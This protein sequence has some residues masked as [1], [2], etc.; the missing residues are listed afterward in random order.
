MARQLEDVS[1]ATVST[2]SFNA[3]L[4][5]ELGEI[6]APTTT[7]S[8]C[9]PFFFHATQNAVGLTEGVQRLL[10]PHRLG[11][12]VNTHP[13]KVLEA[14][15]LLDDFYL[16]LIDWAPQG[17]PIA[18]A[19]GKSIVFIER[20]LG[21]RSRS[22]RFATASDGITCIKHAPASAALATGLA[23]GGFLLW[24]RMQGVPFF[25]LP[26]IHTGRI[27]AISWRNANL[28]SVGGRDRKIQHI[29]TRAAS[30][31]F[32]AASSKP[33]HSQEICGLAWD[34][35]GMLLAS[36]GND[37][38]LLV[39][40]ARQMSAEPLAEYTDHSAAVKAIAWSPALRNVLV[41]GGGT[42]D[43]RL[44]LRDISAVPIIVSA[45]DTGSQVSPITTSLIP[46]F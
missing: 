2:S 32:D 29:D 13:I 41:S 25:S 4:K 24:D 46:C 9:S 42:L 23:S 22:F 1:T 8:L 39:W 16:N 5:L 11:R 12:M 18:V 19:L 44:V 6:S 30:S 35:T 10:Q 14:P 45:M 34:P 7:S 43:R 21:R 20:A 3:L 31:F 26:H 15:G 37:N 38:R 27:G 17:G 40:D 33:F 36:G 28:L